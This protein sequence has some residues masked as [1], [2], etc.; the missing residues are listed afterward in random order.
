MYDDL[1][2][3]EIISSIIVIIFAIFYFVGNDGLKAVLFCL[4]AVYSA[5]ELSNKIYKRCMKNDC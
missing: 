5:E 1:F 3:K 4:I 2:I